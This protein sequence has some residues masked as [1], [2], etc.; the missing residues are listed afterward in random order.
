MGQTLERIKT[1]WAQYGNC[2]EKKAELR[3]GNNKTDAEKGWEE[4][5]SRQVDKSA[6]SEKVR[7]IW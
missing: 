7:N 2:W 4:R 5:K 6:E 3:G 1:S